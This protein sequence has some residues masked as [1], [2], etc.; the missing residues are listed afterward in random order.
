MQVTCLYGSI[1]IGKTGIIM[2]TAKV[3]PAPIKIGYTPGGYSSFAL[4]MNSSPLTAGSC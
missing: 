3:L 2:G 1:K 4:N